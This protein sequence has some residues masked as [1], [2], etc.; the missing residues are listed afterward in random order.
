MPTAKKNPNAV[1]LGRKGR[2][3]SGRARTANLAPQ[4]RG[5]RAKNAVP[6]RWGGH[7]TTEVDAD[8]SLATPGTP[9]FETSDRAMFALLR[10][11]KATDD[12]SQLRQLADQ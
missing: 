8:T 1:V 6:A 4:R 12:P 2:Q 7:A 5:G 9:V 10:R 3:E 11:I